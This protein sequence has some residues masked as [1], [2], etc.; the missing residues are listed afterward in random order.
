[1]LILTILPISGL[2]VQNGVIINWSLANQM[3][4]T[5]ITNLVIFCNS[6][7]LTSFW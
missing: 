3:G 2:L 7:L 5:S 1:M 4:A 6:T